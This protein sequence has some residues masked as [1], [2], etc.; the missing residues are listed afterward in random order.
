MRTY[1]NNA[2]VTTRLVLSRSVQSS[3][4]REWRV[5]CGPSPVVTRAPEFLT[6]HDGV[7]NIRYFPCKFLETPVSLLYKCEKQT[8]VLLWM[9]LV[10]KVIFY[11][12][13]IIFFLLFK[14]VGLMWIPALVDTCE[15]TVHRRRIKTEEKA[16]VVAFVWVPEFFEF[17]AALAVIHCTIWIIGWIAPGWF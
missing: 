8:F 5:S 17:L 15:H 7:R 3:E 6:F 9:T 14:I 4:I 16:K 10:L 2:H 13:L 1:H 11:V 12:F